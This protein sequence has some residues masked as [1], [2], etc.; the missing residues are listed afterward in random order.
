MPCDILDLFNKFQYNHEE[1]GCKCYHIDGDIDTG[2][3][4][5]VCLLLN[6]FQMLEFEEESMVLNIIW[7]VY[8]VLYS[9]LPCKFVSLID[10]EG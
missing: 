2:L 4:C 5:R 10:I 1:S 8:H 3:P 9:L 6:L 7:Q